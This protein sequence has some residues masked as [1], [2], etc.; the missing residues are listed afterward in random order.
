ML[1]FK[2]PFQFPLD[3][4]SIGHSLYIEVI[5]K[6]V[7]SFLIFLLVQCITMFIKEKFMYLER[8]EGKW[9]R[10]K[11]PEQAKWVTMVTPV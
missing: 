4:T 1:Q 11:Q 2:F 5:L 8:T 7:G 10:E 6:V 3:T 9:P